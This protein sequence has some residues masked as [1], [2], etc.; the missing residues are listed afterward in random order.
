MTS[1][2]T[3]LADLALQELFNYTV[4][5]KKFNINQST[6]SRQHRDIIVFVKKSKQTTL[7]LSNQQ[8]KELIRYIS[9]LIKRDISSLNIIIRVFAYNISKKQS[10]KN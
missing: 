9:K 10:G 3:A 5:A 2:T 7:I 6:L 8:E 1:I 4:T